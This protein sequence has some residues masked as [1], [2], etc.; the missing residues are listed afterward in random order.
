LSINRRRLLLT[1]GGVALLGLGADAA[2]RGWRA[3]GDR[4]PPSVDV[5]ERHRNVLSVLADTILPATETPGALDVG[6]PLW[7][8]HL[9]ADSFA[10]ADRMRVLAGLDLIDSHAMHEFG[11]GIPGL[12]QAQRSALLEGLDRPPR[13]GEIG[14]RV[15]AIVQHRLPSGGPLQRYAESLGAER[16]AFAEAKALI[17]HGYFTSEIVQRELMQITWA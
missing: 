10:P 2:L 17:V 15:R 1:V 3:V 13:F 11:K 9:L 16:R 14:E 8:E 6:V 7:I 4:Q 12:D 5:G